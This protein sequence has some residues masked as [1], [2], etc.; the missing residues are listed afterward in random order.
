VRFFVAGQGLFSL[1]IDA[2]VYEVL[3]EK[4]D[5]ISIPANTPHWFDMGQNPQFVAIRL[6]NNPDGWV[7]NYSGSGI[8]TQFSRLE[9]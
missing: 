4:G 5:L 2:S 3:C 9:N 1:H 6:F 7:A 8:A